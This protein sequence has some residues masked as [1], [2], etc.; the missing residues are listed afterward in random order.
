M[1]YLKEVTVSSIQ[2]TT[3]VKNPLSGHE[4]PEY[5]PITAWEVRGPIGHIS[6]HRTKAKAESAAKEW[7]EFYEKHPVAVE[8]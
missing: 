3:W 2:K 5:G 6:K 1:R 4:W 7:R 8:D